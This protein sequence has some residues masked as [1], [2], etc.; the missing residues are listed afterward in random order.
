[1]KA[2]ERQ[3][4][5]DVIELLDELRKEVP[6]SATYRMGKVGGGMMVQIQAIE[7]KLK[8]LVSEDAQ[9]QDS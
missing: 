8:E 2:T 9:P 6:L 5:H 7:A 3:A 1:M 4:L